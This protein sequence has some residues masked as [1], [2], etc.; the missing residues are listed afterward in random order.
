MAN[1]R[2][3]DPWK[4][5][6]HCRI[7]LEVLD[8]PAWRVLPLSSKALY[9]DMRAK[10]RSTNN[11]NINATLS[12]MRHRGW[13]S[14]ATLSRALRHLLALG[15]IA[16]TRQ[17]GIASMAKVCSLYR[18]TDMPVN[19]HPKQGIAAGAATHDYRNYTSVRDA[20][21][22]IRRQAKKSKVQKLKHKASETEAIRPDIGSETEQ[23]A[24]PKL[25]NLNKG[26]CTQGNDRQGIPGK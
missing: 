22:E 12:E 4:G 21:A 24:A 1:K 19:E 20:E 5:I 16:H 14:S 23:E 10:L 8:S 6:A 9:T 11:G 15:F 7:P 25:Q 2:G 18:F 17:G 13:N 3:L 26:K